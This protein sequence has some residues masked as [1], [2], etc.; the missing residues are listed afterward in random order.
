MQKGKKTLIRSRNHFGCLL[1]RSQSKVEDIGQ[2]V[3][4]ALRMDYFGR[5]AYHHIMTLG[6]YHLGTE[7]QKRANLDRFPEKDI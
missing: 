2:V 7:V 4:A 6:I 1:V 5:Y 3:G